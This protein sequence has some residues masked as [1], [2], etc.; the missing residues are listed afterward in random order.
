MSL[1]R[2]LSGREI[3]EAL[4]I[5]YSNLDNYSPDYSPRRPSEEELSHYIIKDIKDSDEKKGLVQ[6]LYAKAHEIKTICWEM[7]EETENPREKEIEI[8]N[9][10]GSIEE[11]FYSLLDK[12]KSKI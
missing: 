11:V 5:N 7:N 12:Y 8:E 6:W 9:L 10:F 3:L 4:G 2:K 1:E